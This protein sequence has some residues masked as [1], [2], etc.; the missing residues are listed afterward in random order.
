MKVKRLQPI[1]FSACSLVSHA[2]QLLY[3][4]FGFVF[5]FGFRQF[6]VLAALLAVAAADSAYPAYPAPAAYSAPAYNH[7]SYDYVS[8]SMNQAYCTLYSLVATVRCDSET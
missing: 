5:L 3:V 6:L 7:K 2:V 8:R 1:S 4:L